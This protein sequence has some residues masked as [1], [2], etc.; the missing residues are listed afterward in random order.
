MISW[1]T[2]Y[3]FDNRYCACGCKDTDEKNVILRKCKPTT[4][5]SEHRKREKLP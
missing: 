5:G 2:S 3:R 1:R 4:E